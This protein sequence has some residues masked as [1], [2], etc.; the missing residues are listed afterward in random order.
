MSLVDNIVW[1]TCQEGDNIVWG[2]SLNTVD[3]IVWGTSALDNIVWGM[4][5]GDASDEEQQFFPDDV[6]PL[7]GTVID[8]NLLATTPSTVGG[9]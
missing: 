7:P 6:L 9:F 8:P 2:T 1:G 5:A 3:N 4:S